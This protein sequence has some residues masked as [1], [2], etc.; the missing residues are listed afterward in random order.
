MC[1]QVMRTKQQVNKDARVIKHR[2]PSA[3]R[4]ELQSG[5]CRS[6]LPLSAFM[7]ASLKAAPRVTG[8][9]KCCSL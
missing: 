3:G 5:L 6:R 7:R 8:I 9:C 1:I 4:E 2:C